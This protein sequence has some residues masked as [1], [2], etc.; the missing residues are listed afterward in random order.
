M[1]I[2]LPLE[3]IPVQEITYTHAQQRFAITVRQLD[4]S[5]V[6][7]AVNRNGE[8][9]TNSV[10]AAALAPMIPFNYLDEGF[11]N[12]YFETPNGELPHY[13]NFGTTHFL[14]F[15]TPEELEYARS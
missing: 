1:P 9:V 11:G 14:L 13:S 8:V 15:V 7:V 12:F 10:Q 6:T 5:I 3:P 4:S 2:V